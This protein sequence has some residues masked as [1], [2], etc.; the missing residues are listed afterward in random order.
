MKRNEKECYPTPQSLLHGGI[1]SEIK[2][3]AETPEQQKQEPFNQFLTEIKYRQPYTK[4]GFIVY[5]P[6]SQPPEELLNEA[7]LPRLRIIFQPNLGY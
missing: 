3:V 5:E 4:D 1:P 2:K 6:H 7:T